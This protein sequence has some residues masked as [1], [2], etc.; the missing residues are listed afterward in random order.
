MSTVTA[1]PMVPGVF[2]NT[3]KKITDTAIMSMPIIISFSLMMNS[4]INGDNKA[5]FFI[6]GSILL[7]GLNTLLID[8]FIGKRLGNIDNVNNLDTFLKQLFKIKFGDVYHKTPGFSVTF[9]SFVLMYLCLP[10][11]NLP[12]DSEFP[13]LMVFVL[14]L[15]TLSSIVVSYRLLGGIG[16]HLFSIIFGM[17]WGW[18]WYLVVKGKKD[19]PSGNT[20]FSSNSN[21]STKCSRPSTQAFK[22]TVYKNGK[23]VGDINS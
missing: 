6:F 5:L 9:M 20:Y 8:N 7:Y 23:P 15:L 16:I 19:N 2:A 4:F 22:C 14:I 11:R 21:S 18:V 3:L 10:L 12:K 17:L 1:T 13:L